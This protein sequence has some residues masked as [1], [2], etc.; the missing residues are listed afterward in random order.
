M[1][2]CV[3]QIAILSYDIKIQILAIKKNVIQEGRLVAIFFAILSLA[4]FEQFYDYK[5]LDLRISGLL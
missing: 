3:F 4:N 2:M 5:P 1:I